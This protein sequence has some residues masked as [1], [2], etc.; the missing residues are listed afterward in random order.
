MEHPTIGPF[1]DALERREIIPTVPPVPDT[2]LTQYWETIGKRF[3][4]PV[5]QDTIDRNCYDG[6]NR[7]PKFIVPTAADGLKAGT[8]IDGLALVSA[9]WCRYCQGTTEAGEAIPSNDPQWGRLQAK[10]EEAKSNPSAWLGMND[11][12][13]DVGLNPKFKEAFAKALGKVQTNG[14]ESAMKDYIDYKA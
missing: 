4:N 6:A 8:S 5:L 2:N 11:V 7:Q 13:G 14:V 1:L 9:M 12:Y 3:T 10:A